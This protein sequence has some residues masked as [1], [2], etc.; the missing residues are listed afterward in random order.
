[1]HVALP[2]RIRPNRARLM[3]RIGA[4]CFTTAPAMWLIWERRDELTGM[5][6]ELSFDGKFLVALAIAGFVTACAIAFL[7]FAL[8]ALPWAPFRHIDVDADGVTMRHWLFKRRILHRDIDGWGI[9]ERELRNKSAEW[10][11]VRWRVYSAVAG[12]GIGGGQRVRAERPFAMTVSASAYT[13]LASNKEHFAGLLAAFLSDCHAVRGRRATVD[14]PEPLASQI[15][16]LNRMAPRTP[17]P[18]RPKRQRSRMPGRFP[19]NE[20][21]AAYWSGQAFQA[22]RAADDHP[23]SDDAAARAWTYEQLA[24]RDRK[25]LAR[26]KR[27]ARLR[28]QREH[29]S[30]PVS[31]P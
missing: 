7:A 13:P 8:E 3:M 23:A 26:E 25:R 12:R 1:M 2:L 11:T 22:M 19:T 21:M 4:L 20:D 15:F 30:R 31:G 6:L 14:A 28:A 29:A 24:R 9:S 18:S 17:R 10:P 5:L 27:E 16:P